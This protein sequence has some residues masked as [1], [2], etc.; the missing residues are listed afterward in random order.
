LLAIFPTVR[1]LR[2]ILASGWA[3][4]IGTINSLH[5]D[6]DDVEKLVKREDALQLAREAMVS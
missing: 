6:V 5:I 4:L 2:D 1:A 3:E